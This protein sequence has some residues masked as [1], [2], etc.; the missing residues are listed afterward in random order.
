MRRIADIVGER[1][2]LTDQTDQFSQRIV[3]RRIGLLVATSVR[4][5]GA[6]RS[7]PVVVRHTH[8]FPVTGVDPD[9]S[10]KDLV[11]R[12]FRA[13]TSTK[14]SAFLRRPHAKQPN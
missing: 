8:P 9:Q 5:I 11:N 7:Q 4:I 12:A 2:G 14:I 3:D 13:P 10:P 1:I 6:I